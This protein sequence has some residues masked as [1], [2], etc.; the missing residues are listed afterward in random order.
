[1]YL[2]LPADGNVSCSEIFL[3]KN[4]RRRTA[5]KIAVMLARSE[6]HEDVIS[7]GSLGKGISYM[8]FLPPRF[9]F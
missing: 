8:E 9:F 7:V 5:S 6:L 4:P 3:G 2:F 1:M